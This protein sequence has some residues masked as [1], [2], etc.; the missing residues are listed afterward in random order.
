MFLRFAAF[1]LCA[2]AISFASAQSTTSGA[3]VM[4]HMRGTSGTMGMAGRMH[5]VDKSDHFTTETFNRMYD[6]AAEIYRKAGIPEEKIQ[7]LRELDMKAWSA[8]TNGE[9]IDYS[10]IRKERMNVLTPEEIDKLRQFR[11]QGRGTR[12]ANGETTGTRHTTETKASE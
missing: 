3:E 10:A 8:Q 9:K 2:G 5:Q 4:H 12:G 7:K 1:A 6:Q 11:M